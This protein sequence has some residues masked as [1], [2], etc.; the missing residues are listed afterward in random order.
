MDE[1]AA[2]Q[3][4]PLTGVHQ[5]VDLHAAV[6]DELF[7]VEGSGGG[8]EGRGD[9]GPAVQNGAGPDDDVRSQ[10]PPGDD[11]GL[12]HDSSEPDLTGDGVEI[13]VRPVGAMSDHAVGSLDVVHGS[14][15]ESDGPPVRTTTGRPV[16]I[17]AVE[18]ASNA[19][20]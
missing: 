14:S 19:W 12:L 20:R 5:S 8:V 1:L 11:C 7:V 13:R 18:S 4:P 9:H 16:P 6:E 17:A 2:E 10:E 15:P 3:P